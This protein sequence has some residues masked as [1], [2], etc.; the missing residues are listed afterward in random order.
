MARL[1]GRHGLIIVCRIVG[2]T[3]VTGH[4]DPRASQVRPSVTAVREK[5]LVDRGGAV[6]DKNG[7]GPIGASRIS[8]RI[9][10]L[11]C[12][13]GGGAGGIAQR[14]HRFGDPQ[15]LVGMIHLDRLVARRMADVE[16]V[17]EGEIRRCPTTADPPIHRGIDAVHGLRDLGVRPVVG[18]SVTFHQKNAERDRADHK[19]AGVVETAPVGRRFDDPPRLF[20][21]DRHDKSIRSPVSERFLHAWDIVRQQLRPL[22]TAVPDAG[23]D[24]G[25]GGPGGQHRPERSTLDGK[26]L[27]PAGETAWRQLDDCCVRRKN[28]TRPPSLLLHSH[29]EI[30]QGLSAL[31]PADHQRLLRC[32]FC[33]HPRRQQRQN[34]HTREHDSNVTHR[35]PSLSMG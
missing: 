26:R 16:V 25:N 20:S 23:C 1:V 31:R 8:Q 22:K 4:G 11:A 14:C 9:D 2:P 30:L 13:G 29:E 17:R 3:A 6:H 18:A 7:I 21:I 10:V 32:F 35:D 5:T 24:P 33:L 34:Q 19:F 15:P 12:P 28:M 27:L